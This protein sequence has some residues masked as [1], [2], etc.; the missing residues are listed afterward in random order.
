VK[1]GPDVLRQWLSPAAVSLAAA[2]VVYLATGA[3]VVRQTERATSAHEARIAALER[4]AAVS[5]ALMLRVE[6]ALESNRETLT[7]V[8]VELARGRGQ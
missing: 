5:E 6:K 1:L 2:V 3:V 8:R 4:Q 7:A